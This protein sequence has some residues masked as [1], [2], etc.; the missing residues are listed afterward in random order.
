MLIADKYYLLN[1][2]LEM[3]SSQEPSNSKV[4]PDKGGYPGSA[5][6]LRREPV[7][8]P[9][10]SSTFPS[11][12]PWTGQQHANQYIDHFGD[13]VN[14][15]KF[16]ACSA[17]R[18]PGADVIEMPNDDESQADNEQE[19]GQKKKDSSQASLVDHSLLKTFPFVLYKMLM[20][21][22]AE[23]NEHILSWV[24]GHGRAFH[25]HDRAALEKEIIPR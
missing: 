3:N 25:V 6:L 23:G 21:A 19:R 12:S 2:P 13:P 8:Y 10:R 5:T 22:H 18:P 14:D 7:N 15:L 9:T 1:G 4:S 24:P 17:L 11:A 16:F 20:D